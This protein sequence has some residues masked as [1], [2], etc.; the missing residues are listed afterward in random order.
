VLK[1]NQPTNHKNCQ[2]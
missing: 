1:P 2:I